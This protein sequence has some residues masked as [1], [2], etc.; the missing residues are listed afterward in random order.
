MP[1]SIAYLKFFGFEA[2]I[3]ISKEKRATFDSKD[4]KLIFV[5]YEK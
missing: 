2:F 4:A 5:G 3:S 1:L